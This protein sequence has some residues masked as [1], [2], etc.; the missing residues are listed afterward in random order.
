MYTEND[1]LGWGRSDRGKSSRE[2]LVW[3][4]NSQKYYKEWNNMLS[5]PI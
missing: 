2:C 4:D 5:L 1:K 3:S